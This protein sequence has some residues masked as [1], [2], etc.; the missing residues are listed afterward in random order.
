[1][2]CWLATSLG[3]A[4]CLGVWGSDSP[5]LLVWSWPK[6]L[7]VSRTRREARS[8]ES[9]AQDVVQQIFTEYLD[10]S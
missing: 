10:G 9:V 4:E 3:A 6:R 5:T 1:M 7:V 8:A 2:T